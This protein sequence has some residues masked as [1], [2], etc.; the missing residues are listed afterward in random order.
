MEAPESWRTDVLAPLLWEIGRVRE[1]TYFDCPWWPDL[2]VSPGQSLA[3]RLKKMVKGDRFKFTNAPE[4]AKVADKFVYQPGR[5]P[6]FGGAGWVDEL[7]PALLRHPGFDGSGSPRLRARTAH[8]HAF[9]VDLRPR[10][11]RARRRLSLAEPG[12]G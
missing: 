1:H 10:T 9:V 4:D 5:W 12:G 7:L 11:P 2:Q 3:D 6:Y 8:L